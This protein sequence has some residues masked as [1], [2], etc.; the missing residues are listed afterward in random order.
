[1]QDFI[2]KFARI[3]TPFV[4]IAAALLATVPPLVFQLP[5]HE[6]I[7]RA[8]SLIVM[9]CPCALVVSTPVALVAA[10]GAAARHGVLVKGGMFLELAAKTQ[11]VTLDKTGTLTRGVPA[12]KAV[13]GAPGVAPDAVLALAASVEESSEHPLAEAIMTHAREAGLTW[14]NS[15]DFF[16]VMGKGA[17][18][19]VNGVDCAVGTPEWAASRGTD[20]TMLQ[21]AIDF[22]RAEGRTVVAVIEQGVAKGVISLADA[23]RPESVAAVKELHAIGVKHVAMLTGDHPAAAKAI[24]AECG[25]DDVRA[26]LMPDDK[27]RIVKELKARHGTLVMV[28]DGVNDAPAL[29][30]ASY[31]VSM[32]VAGSGVALETA[33]VALM[34][35]DLS[36]LP[37]LIRLGRKTMTI[38]NQNIAFALG[39]KLIALVAV[40][41]GWL[42]LWLAVLS[43]MGATFLVTLNALRLLGVQEGVLV[44]TVAAGA[45]KVA[46]DHKH[47]H[48]HKHAH[49]HHV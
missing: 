49:K 23:I 48:A 24:A 13:H 28:G 34:S 42:T 20:V 9:A 15:D 29:A 6:W 3:Y 43:D 37:F 32:G 46:H 10:I 40:L 1:M 7:Y 11:A 47:R 14:P 12:V 44:G 39:V 5:W 17:E 8:L 22:E 41:P 19:V 16:A 21:T 26:G 27:L 33:D 30:E 38:I 36:K 45:A 25:I 4:L 35:D 31:G 2:D 18:A